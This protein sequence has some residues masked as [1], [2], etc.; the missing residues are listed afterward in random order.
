MAEVA[1]AFIPFRALLGNRDG[2][3]VS[4]C[5]SLSF[6]ICCYILL[7]FETFAHIF[8]WKFIGGNCG[9]SATTPF[10]P[11]PSGFLSLS[12]SLYIYIYIYVYIIRKLSMRGGRAA[13]MIQYNIPYYSILCYIILYHAILYDTTAIL[14]P[15]I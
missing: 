14:Y 7:Y 5:A 13:A 1:L 3:C 4:D 9:A 2:H 6:A 8:P 12:L 15:N 10:V 11:T